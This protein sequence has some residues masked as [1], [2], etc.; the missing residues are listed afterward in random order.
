MNNLF[1]DSAVEEVEGMQWLVADPSRPDFGQVVE[2]EAV[3]EGVVMRDTGIIEKDGEE[4]FC[5]AGTRHLDLHKAIDLMKP[6]KMEDW[7]LAGP[8]A[9]P[10]FLK[11]VRSGATDLVG[12]HLQWAQ[13]SGIS[14][15]AASKH[16]HRCLMDTLKA[17]I[18][19]DQFDASNS[20]GI[21]VLVRRVIQI[22]TATARSP[23]NPD[24]SG[25]EL[26]M[27]QPIGA[28]GEAQ[29]LKFSEWVGTRLKEKATI[30]KQARLYKEEFSKGKGGAGSEDGAKGKGKGKPKAK[31]K[32]VQ[33]VRCLDKLAGIEFDRSQLLHRPCTAV[34][35]LAHDRLYAAFQEAGEC[36]SGYSPSSCLQ[37]M[38]K[39]HNLYEGEPSNLAPFDAQKLKILKSVVKPKPI[40]DLLP[41]HLLPL[42]Q[43]H[44]TTIERSLEDRERALREDPSACPRQ[45]YWD[46]VLRGDE[47][48]RVRFIAD[49][50]RVGV[51]HFRKR[52]RS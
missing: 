6:I 10:E 34:Q 37:D 19:Y 13:H 26:I 52:I 11:A 9:A 29:T 33:M 8:K 46:P 51:V 31:A 44:K 7:P 24:F 47:K 41:P 15:Y 28:G 21:E 39:S 48:V 40:E 5:E 18:C 17:L 23:H 25:L 16:E 38:M 43:N 22:E 1:N 4:V 49:L 36:P 32:V 2:P 27:E 35:S 12:Y 14:P 42:I 20:L 45:P 3:D 30:Q 50:A